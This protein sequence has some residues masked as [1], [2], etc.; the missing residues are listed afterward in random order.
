MVYLE[1]CF[2]VF[3]LI[4]TDIRSQHNS[5]LLN[6]LLK[7]LQRLLNGEDLETYDLIKDINQITNR[8]R[9]DDIKGSNIDHL[10][11]FPPIYMSLLDNVLTEAIH[12]FE[13]RDYQRAYDL[14]DAVHFLPQLLITEDWERGEYWE[15][16]IIPYRIDW[17]N[18]FLKSLDSQ[19]INNKT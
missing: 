8:I 11:L 1:L 10:K 14:I 12:V 19:I 3:L 18:D 4:R 17:N 2:R 5:D 9:L 7:S 6:V 16:F 15:S 13:M